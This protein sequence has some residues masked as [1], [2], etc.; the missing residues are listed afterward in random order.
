MDIF[1]LMDHVAT[2]KEMLSALL[3]FDNEV[4]TLL[5]TTKGTVVK[6]HYL[7]IPKK[8][9][10]ICNGP[11]CVLCD[12]GMTPQEFFLLPVY[13]PIKKKV[14]VLPISTAN[15]NGYPCSWDE[16]KTAS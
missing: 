2:K 13:D 12:I 1:A 16:L 14:K 9:F 5:F 15:T 3:I 4:C 10:V 7:E 11:G 8:M 6:A